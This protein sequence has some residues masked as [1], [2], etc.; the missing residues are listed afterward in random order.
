M[1]HW[2]MAVGVVATLAMA[3]PAEAAVGDWPVVG[4]VYKIVACL[5]T[6]A[7]TLGKIVV[8]HATQATTEVLQTVASCVKFV[9]DTTVS[10]VPEPSTPTEAP[11]VETPQ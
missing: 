7:G 1:K 9:I 11:H 4:Q 8:T 6:D 5:I 10:V 3:R 2:L